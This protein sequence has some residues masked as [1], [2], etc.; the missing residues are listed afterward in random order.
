MSNSDWQFL[1]SASWCRWATQFFSSVI[2]L[3]PVYWSSWTKKIYK[4]TGVV[5]RRTFSSLARFFVFF[6]KK[7][8]WQKRFWTW[9]QKKR[10]YFILY[11]NFKISKSNISIKTL[12][13]SSVYC[14][15]S[16]K[17]TILHASFSAFFFILIFFLAWR[18]RC[19]DWKKNSWCPQPPTHPPP[20]FDIRVF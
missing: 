19:A 16:I 11:T 12:F 4:I 5:S 8:I 9:R 10:S 14:M 13:C 7:Y 18:S 17:P 6:Q 20:I 1:A 15:C 3:S 2:L